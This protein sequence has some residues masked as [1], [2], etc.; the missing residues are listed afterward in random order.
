MKVKL[1]YLGLVRNSTGRSEEDIYL[2]E[3]SSLKD[4]LNELAKTYGEKFGR[5]INAK[6]HLWDPTF[7]VAVN[8]KLINLHNESPILLKD[9][10]VISL[11]TLISGG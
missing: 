5:F 2:K 1:L 6:E 11:M 7:I 3:G 9:G 4:L 10:D 8:G